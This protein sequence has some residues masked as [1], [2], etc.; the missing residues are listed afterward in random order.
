MYKSIQRTTCVINKLT[1][2]YISS[3]VICNSKYVLHLLGGGSAPKDLS[4]IASVVYSV[5]GFSDTSITGME[6]SIDPAMQ[7]LVELNR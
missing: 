6:G 3:Q 1:L 5:L 2:L 7:L 4:P